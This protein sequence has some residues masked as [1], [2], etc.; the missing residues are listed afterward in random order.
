LVVVIVTSLLVAGT[1]ELTTVDRVLDSDSVADP[2][3]VV[4]TEVSVVV[5]TTLPEL[6]VPVM[7]GSSVE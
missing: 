7:D 5:E 4:T 3:V 1:V 6:L 2:E